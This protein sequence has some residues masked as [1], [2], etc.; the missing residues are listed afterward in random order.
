MSPTA[1]TPHQ[2]AYS[3]VSVV[4]CTCNGERW[5]EEQLASIEGQTLPPDEV[6]IGDDASRDGTYGMPSGF[7]TPHAIPGPSDKT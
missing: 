3:G 5:L 2:E 1:V 4:L 7:L 6:V